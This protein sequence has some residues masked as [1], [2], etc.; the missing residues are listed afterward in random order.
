MC[1]IVG[2]AL[3]G[4]APVDPDVIRRMTASLEHRGPDGE[5]AFFADGVGLGHRR[6]AVVDLSDASA[7]PMLGGSATKRTALTFNGEIYN[8]KALRSELGA[9]GREVHSTGDTEVLLAALETWGVGA[10]D[11][12]EGMFA[13]GYWDESARTLLLARDRYGEKPLY[14]APLGPT[15]ARGSCSPRSCGRSCCI[16]GCGRSER[17]MLRRSRSSSSTSSC[18][19]RG[20]SWR[21]CERSPRGASFA[22]STALA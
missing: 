4:G 14:Y 9:V 10:L 3:R 5:G 6:L 15:G 21:T 7:Q 11:R 22:G 18:R 12:L 2:V 20:A 8:W 1:G 19:R 16:P 17:S 13:F